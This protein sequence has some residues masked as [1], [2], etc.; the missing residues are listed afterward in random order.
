METIKRIGGGFQEIFLIWFVV[1]IMAASASAGP[2]YPQSGGAGFKPASARKAADTSFSAVLTDKPVK[3]F[4]RNSFMRSFID[5]SLFPG[6]SDPESSPDHLLLRAKLTGSGFESMNFSGGIGGNMSLTQER[7]RRAAAKDETYRIMSNMLSSIE[8][9][10]R[11]Q[12]A[13]EPY[14]R[15]IELYRDENG[16]ISSNYL[17]QTNNNSAGSVRVFA[18]NLG[19]SSSHNLNVMVNIHD[20]FTVSLLNGDRLITQ[21]LIP[22]GNGV[23]GLETNA[24][25]EMLFRYSMEF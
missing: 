8:L 6:V 2:D 24:R 4:A 19:V 15:L 13:L 7:Y 16:G 14:T 9:V 23:I 5:K 25:S 17:G 3:A 10:A 1:S 11:L 18:V 22:E 12:K 20:R 21:Y